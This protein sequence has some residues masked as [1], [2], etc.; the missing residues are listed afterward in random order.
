MREPATACSTASLDPRDLRRCADVDVLIPNLGGPGLP[1]LPIG[2]VTLGAGIVMV[3]SGRPR[4]SV[5][6][7]T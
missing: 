7:A 5:S 1:L 6:R 2:L 3:A 4:P